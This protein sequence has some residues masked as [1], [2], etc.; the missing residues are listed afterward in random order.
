MMHR[1]CVNTR[2]VTER[3]RCADSAVIKRRRFTSTP[4]ARGVNGVVSATP[5]ET[6]ELT[7]FRTL[8]ASRELL[9]DR[10]LDRERS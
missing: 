2:I 1:L 9:V 10:K 4:V 3:V 7:S 6:T 5:L 8:R